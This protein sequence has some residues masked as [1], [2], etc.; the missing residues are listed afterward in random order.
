[1]FNAAF[2]V[3]LSD[4]EGSAVALKLDPP[5]RQARCFWCDLLSPFASHDVKQYCLQQRK[6]RLNI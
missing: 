1:M 4:S 2:I 3:I 6:L 5:L